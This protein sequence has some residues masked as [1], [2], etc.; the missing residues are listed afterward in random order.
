M[1]TDERLDRLEDAVANLADIMER[2]GGRFEND[3]DPTVQ[4]LG[5]KFRAFTAAVASERI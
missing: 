3:G 1:T 4:V 2:R 5:E